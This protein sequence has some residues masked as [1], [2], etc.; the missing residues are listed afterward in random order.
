MGA[1]LRAL[2]LRGGRMKKVGYADSKVLRT[3]EV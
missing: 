2:C 3:V 1:G